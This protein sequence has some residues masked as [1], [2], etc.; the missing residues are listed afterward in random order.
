MQDFG[1]N[2]YQKK[3]NEATELCIFIK[4]KNIYNNKS[5]PKTIFNVLLFLQKLEINLFFRFLFFYFPINL[6]VLPT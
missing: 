1:K 6:V 3:V 4:K 5:T 2:P